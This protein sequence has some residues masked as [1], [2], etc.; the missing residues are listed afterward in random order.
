MADHPG[1]QIRMTGQE[2]AGRGEPISPGRLA[3]SQDG[4]VLGIVA[5]QVISD[6]V[7]AGDHGAHRELRARAAAYSAARISGARCT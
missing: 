5:E 7:Q 4:A 6:V 3:E 2:R 1:A